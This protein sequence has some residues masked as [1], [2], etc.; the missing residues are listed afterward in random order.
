MDEIVHIV[1]RDGYDTFRFPVLCRSRLP[2]IRQG[3]VIQQNSVSFSWVVVECCVRTLTKKSVLTL[4]CSINCDDIPWTYGLIEHSCVL[5]FSKSSPNYTFF[6]RNIMG[7]KQWSFRTVAHYWDQLLRSFQCK[8][9]QWHQ[10]WLLPWYGVYLKFP[11]SS[12]MSRVLNAK[13]LRLGK[14]AK[15][16]LHFWQ[17]LILSFNIDNL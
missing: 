3:F 7:M 12:I 4:P 2:Q 5:V 9:G 11:S 6:F 17:V 13:L 15:K 14:Y 16:Q 8:T 10:L 1:T